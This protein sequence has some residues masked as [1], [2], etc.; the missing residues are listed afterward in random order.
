MFKKFNGLLSGILVFAKNG[1]WE[2]ANFIKK[3]LK[4]Q[5]T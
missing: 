3:I 1:R 5:S 2:N 4:G